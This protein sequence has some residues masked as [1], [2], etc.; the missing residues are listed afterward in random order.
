MNQEFPASIVQIN[1]LFPLKKWRILDLKTLLDKSLYH[2]SYEA[3]TKMLQRLEKKK[4]IESFIDPFTK[5]KFVYLTKEGDSY[6]GGTDNSPMLST[7]SLIHDSRVVKLVLELLNLSYF[8]GSELEHENKQ[9]GSFNNRTGNI[10]D[11]VLL[12]KKDEQKFRVALELELTRKTKTRYLAKAGQYLNTTYYDFVIYFFQSKSLLESYKK[13]ID[14][15]FG[16][17]SNTK[18]IYAY[19]EKLFLKGFDFMESRIIFLNRKG[20]FSTIFGEPI[21]VH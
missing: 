8:T 7:N 12:G 13:N 14:E 1:Y 4:M 3:F 20:D 18:I 6:L 2:H 16:T 17:D 10:P 11:A 19:N 21:E 9:R 15:K 5:N